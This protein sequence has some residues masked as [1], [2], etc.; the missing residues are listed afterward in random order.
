MCYNIQYQKM[1][2][3]S[4]KMKNDLSFSEKYNIYNSE[5]NSVWVSRLPLSSRTKLV[6]QRNDIVCIKDLLK[7]NGNYLLSLDSFGVNSINEV[8]S[9]I[10]SLRSDISIGKFLCLASD[11]FTNESVTKIKLPPWIMVWLLENDIK[12]IND[13]LCVSVQKLASFPE[14]NPSYL[15]KICD[16]IDLYISGQSSETN[17]RPNNEPSVYNQ[18]IKDIP[19]SY[20]TKKRLLE[21]G[22]TTVAKL[23]KTPIES[24]CEIRGFGASCV[25]EV[26]EYLH[27]LNISDTDQDI[28]SFESSSIE[29]ET[30][31]APIPHTVSVH[32]AQILNGDFSFIDIN[33]ENS[34]PYTAARYKTA[35]ET[36]GKVLVTA[37]FYNT[38][39]IMDI[40]AVLS[41]FRTSMDKAGELSNLLNSVPL[42][43]RNCKING[44]IDA[45]AQTDKARDALHLIVNNENCPLKEIVNFE[46]S[47]APVNYNLVHRFLTWCAYDLKSEIHKAISLALKNERTGEVILARAK[48][49][50]LQNVGEMFNL[51]RERVRQIE[52]KA[53]RVFARGLGEARIIPKIF[54]DNNGNTVIT[55]ERIKEYSPEYGEE[56]VYLLKI[57]LMSN[58]NYYTYDKD[59]DVF[60]YGD[61]TLTDGIQDYVDSMPDT[62]RADQLEAYLSIAVEE[63]DFPKDLV[64]KTISTSYKITGEVYHKSHLFKTSMYESILEKYFPT[65]LK[66]CDPNQM[67]RFKELIAQEY[68]AEI[69]LP[70]NNHAIAA[71][72]QDIATICD[73]GTYIARSNQAHMPDQLARD[74]HD[75]IKTNE[76]KVFLTNTLFAIFE[77][78]LLKVGINN[79][80][81]LQSILREKYED[82]FIF[83]RDYIS[84]D[85]SF[86][87][88]HTEIVNFIKESNYPVSKQQIF[89]RFPGLTEVVL[90][91]ATG[92]NNIINLFGQYLHAG[93]LKISFEE[94][95]RFRAIIADLV[96]DGKPHHSE[97]LF[98]R[99]N[100]EIPGMLS[101]NFALY[102][103]SAFSIAENL[104][105]NEF[106]FSRPLFAQDGVEDIGYATDRMK[107]Y[108]YKHEQISFE[109][110]S[111]YAKEIHYQIFSYLELSESLNDKFFM[112]SEKGLI[113]IE[114]TGI[115]EDIAKQVEN[116][117]CDS[118]SDAVPIRE[119][120][121]IYSL[122]PISVNW[123]EWLVLSTLKKWSSKLSVA[124]SSPILRMAVPLVSPIGKMDAEKFAGLAPS[125]N[126][127]FCSDST[128][129][130]STD[131]LLMELIDDD[132]LWE[133]LT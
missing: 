90:S 127:E 28:L 81:Y 29:Q 35:Y 133:D 108:I 2:K 93:K 91:F 117:V 48:G 20:R 69:K 42:F 115:T 40:I 122:P 23:I 109:E 39:E 101:R 13:L 114:Q 111:K 104:F 123:T 76:S 74:I 65:G 78:K 9:V 92:D 110:M 100:T 66:A 67:D 19:F 106:Q 5:Y 113:S 52:T 105:R 75:Y 51:T 107:D 128:D 14:Y 31:K 34:L 126:T 32:K 77:D 15:N 132:S 4:V 33:D 11:A 70:D 85:A 112:R 22:I 54:A 25:K 55:P 16:G 7:A 38:K 12:S 18:F 60:V 58:G 120:P 37:C 1:N 49:E 72:L 130:I 102:P 97:E 3:E 21:N 30:R 17:P 36:L 46:A 6:L 24:L 61:S 94:K 57:L 62:F 103:F 125:K 99:T 68:G 63:E 8:E 82:E 121:C 119:L 71:R 83:R 43:R 26:E 59:L 44:F 64:E 124:T 41:D 45:F 89:D 118:I 79:K 87:S 73:R 50:T 56:L 10:G 86:T 53:K 116:I 95:E 84:R 98:I 47:I 80:Y 129:D 27:G 88:I 96:S 131:D